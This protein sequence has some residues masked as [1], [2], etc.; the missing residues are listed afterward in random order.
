M[1]DNP[2]PHLIHRTEQGEK[3]LS[4]VNGYCWKI[5]RSDD[6]DLVLVDRWISRNHAMLQQMGNSEPNADAYYLIDLGSRNG[7]FINTRRVSTPALLSHG[8]RLTFGQTEVEFHHPAHQQPGAARLGDGLHEHTA[9]ATLHVRRL[10]SVLV[11]DIRDFTVLTQ[12]IDENVLSE[13]VGSWFRQAG[14]IIQQHGSWVDKYIGDA[15]M[16]VWIHGSQQI[17]PQEVMQILQALNDLYEMTEELQKRFSLPFHLRVGAGINSGYAMVGN[18]GSSQR[19]DYTALGDTV[20]AAFRLES[21]TK[22]IKADV[23]LGRDTYGYLIQHFPNTAALFQENK[24][25]L[26]G[27]EQLTLAYSCS[28]A[29]MRELLDLSLP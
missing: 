15:V 4:L 14:Q 19:P 26:K 6:N 3:Q 24:V 17:E 16:A 22:E 12:K 18:A 7:T 10:I 21:S 13:L 9:T 5:G 25:Q 23:A 2:V 1:I 8:D 11:L 20:N 27:Y 29:R 28:F